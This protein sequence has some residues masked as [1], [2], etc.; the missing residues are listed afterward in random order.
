MHDIDRTQPEVWETYEFGPTAFGY[1][2]GGPNGYGE[3]GAQAGGP[4]GYG[5]YGEAGGYGEYGAQAS[6]SSGYG[7][8]GE[9]S[10][11]GEYGA[12]AG[13]PGGY[14]EFAMES[15]LGE[16]TELELTAEL[17]EI[18]SEAELDHFLGGLIGRVARKFLPAPLVNTLQGALK[19]YLPGIG[20]A[21]G[22]AIAPGIGT[23]LGSAL[24]SAA[25]GAFGLET[26]GLS[27]EDREFE[28]ARQFVRF[29][30]TAAQETALAPGNIPPQVAVQ[31]ALNAAAQQFAPGLLNPAPG[32]GPLPGIGIPVQPRQARTGRWVRRG[33]H[34][35]LLGVYRRP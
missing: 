22:T 11:Y 21:L 31:H 25:S 16:E 15:P 10:G 1:E 33:P 30:T 26:E 20:A 5:E 34:I 9:A 12:E 19:T 3:Y 24:G 17:L 6:E 28:E 14:G 8:Y 13:G 18:G 27:G 2:T 7:E 4:G 29:A 32:A 23:S 35:L